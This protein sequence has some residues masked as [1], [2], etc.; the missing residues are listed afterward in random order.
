MD[1]QVKQCVRRRQHYVVSAVTCARTSCVRWCKALELCEEWTGS[2]VT[3]MA[4]HPAKARSPAKY[5]TVS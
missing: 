4:V 1:G 3:R 2:G 5:T